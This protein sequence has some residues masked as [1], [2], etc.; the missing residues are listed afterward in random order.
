MELMKASIFVGFDGRY[1]T[2]DDIS[3]SV[4]LS[5][6]SPVTTICTIGL[7]SKKLCILLTQYVYMLLVGLTVG[8]ETSPERHSS[9]SL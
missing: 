1:R 3:R 2:Q 6:S 4:R 5:L 8:I 9:V 7:N